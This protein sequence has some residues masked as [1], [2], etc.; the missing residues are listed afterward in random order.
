[1]R[2][3]GVARHRDASWREN[4]TSWI[5]VDRHNSLVLELIPVQVIQARPTGGRVF[6]AVKEKK[7]REKSL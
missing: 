1:V 2:H 6:V 7:E 4:D 5:V 3:S